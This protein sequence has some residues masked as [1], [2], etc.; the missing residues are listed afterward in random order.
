MCIMPFFYQKLPTHTYI[1]VIH[2]FLLIDDVSVFSAFIVTV[3]FILT[4]IPCWTENVR[5]RDH[6]VEVHTKL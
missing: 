3:R 6:K 2:S 4:F 5:D 1:C